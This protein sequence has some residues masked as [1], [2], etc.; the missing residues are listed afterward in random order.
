MRH[1]GVLSVLCLAGLLGTGAA[2]A[3]GD[4]YEVQLVGGSFTPAPGVR[5][6]AVAALAERAVLARAAGG[7]S[8]HALVQLHEIPGEAERDELARQ[9]LELGA[10]VPG[11]AFVAA[12]AVER[13][14]AVA[15]LPELRWL[16]AW[17]PEQKLH[18]RLVGGGVGKVA[19]WARDKEEPG[20]L[21]VFVLLHADVDLLRLDRLAQGVGARVLSTVQGLNG[22]ALW[23]PEP[24]LARLAAEEEVLWI[25]EAPAPLTPT[26]DGA[27]GSLRSDPLLAAPYN[28][29]G[30]GVRLFVYDG[31]QARAT[32]ETFNPGTGSRV[33]NLDATAVSEHA[34]HTAGTAAGDG[35]GSTGLKGKGVAPGATILTAGIEWP[36][37]SIVLVDT[38][39]DIEADYALARNT[40]NA[41]LATNSLGSNLA[42]SGDFCELEGEY[43]VADSLLDGIV[44]GNNPAVN[45]PL[46]TV[47]ANGNERGYLQCGVDYGTTAPP[48]CAKNPLH[49]GAVNSDGGSMAWFSSWG[50]CKDGRLKP[51]V[52]GP[53]CETGSVPGS[54]FG[55]TSST[56][57]TDSSYGENCGTSMATPAVAGAAALFVQDWRAQGYGGANDRPLPALVKA[58]AIHT[59]KDLGAA[60]PDYSFGYGAVDA[61]ALIDHLRAGGNNLAGSS[62]SR[63]G[64]DSVAHAATDSFTI[65]VPAGTGIL[66]ASL[67]W[68]DPAAAPFALTPLVNNLNLE[69]V[70][71]GGSVTKAWKLNPAQPHLPALLQGNSLDNQEQVVLTDPAAGTYTVRV[72][73]ASVPSGPQGYALALSASPQTHNPNACTTTVW[74]F[75][76]GAQ[77]WTVTNAAI[78][79]GPAGGG[80]QSLRMGTSSGGT[81][82]KDVFIPLGTGFAEWRFQ[83]NL[84]PNQGAGGYDNLQAQIR[85]TAGTVLSVPA[86]VSDTSKPGLWL[87]HTAADLKAWAGQTV[88]LAFFGVTTG[89]HGSAATFWTDQVW[90][91]TC[92][93]LPVTR[94]FPSI[95]DEDGLMIE[96]T[97][98]SNVGGISVYSANGN[99]ALLLG[100]TGSDQ[101]YKSIVSFDTSPIPDTALITGATLRLRR[102]ALTG[103]N[104]YTTHG[105]VL[106][107][108]K[109][110]GF[111]FFTALETSDFQAA[112]TATAV[113]TL[114]NPVNNL[115]WSTGNLTGLGLATL[116][117]TGR[118]QLKLYCALDDNDD[119]GTDS[120]GFYSAENADPNNRPQLVVTYQP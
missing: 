77:G 27:R 48:A 104:P 96:S 28:L 103:T 5:A 110:G 106:A 19:P 67:A 76:T 72:V 55:I 119:L 93:S 73:G 46:L 10:Y 58:L 85:T 11:R 24:A 90:L 45:G 115:D 74:D 88:R 26:N 15:A 113:A 33:T 54:D 4:P 98:T 2:F 116:N 51:V 82:T 62:Q 87:L 75:E 109:A 65:T 79:A 89:T 70:A 35:S 9:G 12:I 83:V 102:G 118:T 68:D 81:A 44:R 3:D 91:T 86:V 56:H 60:G 50:P 111:G 41:D 80:A 47:W 66:K 17:G 7:G 21:K 32:H 108:L 63:W 42:A 52:V 8:V 105:A 94:T 100:D 37:G 107:D 13:V 53:G 38:A 31:G 6:A 20:W 30:G 59:A 14:A 25:E 120:L 112:A 22:G 114:S 29:S 95:G 1:R 117:K 49:V 101:Q 84:D 23:L 99:N 18:P 71:P 36:P 39:G 40:H 57:F 34:T 61:K 16:A 64:T 92:P 97:E 69:I 78:A 43:G